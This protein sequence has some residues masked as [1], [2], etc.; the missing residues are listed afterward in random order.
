MS[1][2][3]RS[4]F[5]LLSNAASGVLSNETATLSVPIMVMNPAMGTTTR[6]AR[7]ETGVTWWKSI[8]V[9]GSLTSTAAMPVPNK[10]AEKSA[11]FILRPSARA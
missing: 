5:A 6:L 10:R 11:R 3:A 2:R 1:T 7:M 9:M 8:A 4:Q